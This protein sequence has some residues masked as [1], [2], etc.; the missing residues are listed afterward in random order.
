V[1]KKLALSTRFAALG[2]AGLPRIGA[3]GLRLDELAKRLDE[4][5]AEE[6]YSGTLRRL[7]DGRITETPG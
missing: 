2:D 6:E 5:A 1:H 7:R 3:K 4:T